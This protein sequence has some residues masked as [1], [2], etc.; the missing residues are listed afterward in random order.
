MIKMIN[1]RNTR[2][3]LNKSKKKMKNKF[4]YWIIKCQKRKMR[5]KIQKI[6]LIK[7]R[8]KLVNFKENLQKN[9]IS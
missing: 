1:N 8:I 5:L 4:N 6:N 3:K 2:I 7:N 9:K